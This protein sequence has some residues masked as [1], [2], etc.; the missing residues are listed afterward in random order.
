MKITKKLICAVM[1][2]IMISMV[3]VS[4]FAADGQCYKTWEEYA[5]AN[6]I[7]DSS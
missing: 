5:A 3:P 1:A 6:E 4:A 7:T 2:L